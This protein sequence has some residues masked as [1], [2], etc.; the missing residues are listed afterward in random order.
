MRT[1][2]LFLQLWIVWLQEF[3]HLRCYCLIVSSVLIVLLLSKYFQM[4]SI[5]YSRFQTP[6]TISWNCCILHLRLNLFIDCSCF[7]WAHYV[8]KSGWYG[9]T[10][11]S[12]FWKTS[13]VRSSFLR[14]MS[15]RHAQLS[16]FG[17][18]L[19]KILRSNGTRKLFPKMFIRIYYVILERNVWSL[20][21]PRAFCKVFD[22]RSVK[23]KR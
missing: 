16:W 5:M 22:D 6:Q 11:K 14:C 20:E 8:F 23:V 3:L 9:N 15:Q 18:E 7:V 4:R 19:W 2:N 13:L 1:Q 21:L 17:R 10:A 12:S